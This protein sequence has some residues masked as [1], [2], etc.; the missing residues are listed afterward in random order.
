[1]CTQKGGDKLALCKSDLLPAVIS[2]DYVTAGRG[3]PCVRE[4]TRLN[5]VYERTWITL[6]NDLTQL[7]LSLG[8]I[9]FALFHAKVHMV[10]DSYALFTLNR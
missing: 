8:E 2:H 4:T 3:G 9:C 6:Q 7:N 10:Q 1:M 5:S